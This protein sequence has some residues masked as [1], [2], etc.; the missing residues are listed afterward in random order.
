MVNG[1]KFIDTLNL[2]FVEHVLSVNVKESQYW[3]R[4]NCC[5][6]KLLKF[7]LKKKTLIR[8]L[9]NIN[10]MTMIFQFHVD[11]EI[12]DFSKNHVFSEMC[13]RNFQSDFPIGRMQIKLHEYSSTHVYKRW[14]KDNAFSCS[15]LVSI[16]SVI[17][18]VLA[19]TTSSS[20][21]I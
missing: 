7:N 12:N 16:V 19:G 4:P 15:L 2:I 11:S 6:E 3:F 1:V 9:T 13:K 14:S 21:L 5:I 17:R 18:F 20:V 8:N 10:T